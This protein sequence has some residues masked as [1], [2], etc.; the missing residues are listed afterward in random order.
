MELTKQ[1]VE[2]ILSLITFR[3]FGLEFYWRVMEKGDGFLIQLVGKDIP[4]CKTNE[5]SEQ[6]GGKHYISKHATQSE[7][8]FKAWKACRD[9]MEH[10]GQEAFYYKGKR[11]IDPH[12]NFFFLAHALESLPRTDR[13]GTY[14][15]NH[16]SYTN[17][18]EPKKKKS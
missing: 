6:R 9:W 5:K 4:C 1:E 7:V 11:V 16:M 2:F 14:Y 8:G 10:E 17:L 3:P 18:P 15:P 13:T 12:V